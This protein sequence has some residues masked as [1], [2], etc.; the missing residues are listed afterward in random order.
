MMSAAQLVQPTV[1]NPKVQLTVVSLV[2]K[3]VAARMVSFL[4]ETAVS[5][6]LNVAVSWK[7]E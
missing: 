3:P 7:M 2:S 6:L 1:W 5:F 4:K